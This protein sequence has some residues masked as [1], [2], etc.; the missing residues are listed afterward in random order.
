MTSF[1]KPVFNERCNRHEITAMHVTHVKLPSVRVDTGLSHS[2]P[3]LSIEAESRER[4]G[5]ECVEASRSLQDYGM[6]KILP[7]TSFLAEWR[8]KIEALVITHGHEDHIG[9]LPWVVPALEPGT[10]IYAGAFSMQLV[11][12]R[13]REFSLF[14]E[15]RFHTF[16]MRE[17]FRA[18]PFEYA[19]MS[20][21]KTS[22]T[23]SQQAITRCLPCS[24]SCKIVEA[25][26]RPFNCVSNTVTR[27]ALELTCKPCSPIYTA[28]GQLETEKS[29]VR[30]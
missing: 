1:D 7:D 2:Y 9:A 10:P 16:Y 29:M 27:D 28:I 20:I 21:C 18:G 5:Q 8:E 19:P 14:D 26:C 15:H 11:Q 13:L 23:R 6:Q 22:A 30:V 3:H 25:S 4:S 12:R 24:V 17:R